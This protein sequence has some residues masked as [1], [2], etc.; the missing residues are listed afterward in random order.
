MWETWV[1]SLGWEDPL[2]KEK[3]TH[4]SILVW[5]IQTPPDFTVHGVAKGQQTG[6]SHL[7]FH[8]PFPSQGGGRRGEKR[9]GLQRM[10]WLDGITD[11]M[12]MNLGKLQETVKDRE[13][14]HA[15]VHGVAES[16][17]TEWLNSNNKE[18]KFLLRLQ[19]RA[20]AGA[21]LDYPKPT[22]CWILWVSIGQP[23][24]I[25]VSGPLWRYGILSFSNVSARSL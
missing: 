8:L 23:C 13:A 17:T 7:L 10:R 6:L 16:D 20:G 2:E 21:E 24:W 11:S 9:R 15:V 22:N 25:N 1:W 14:W 4:S 18:M 12:D 3:A 5:R 19:V